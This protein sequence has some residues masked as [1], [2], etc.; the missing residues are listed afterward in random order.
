MEKF[1]SRKI[2]INKE[3]NLLRLDQALA[4]LSNFT[5]SQIKILI[6]NENVIKKDTAVKDASYRV[7][8]GE[9]YFLKLIIPKEEKFISED[10]PLDIIFEDND[11]IVINK[12]AGMVTHPAPGNETGTLVNA[13]LNHT[14]RKLSTINEKN[15]PGIVHRLDKETS[16]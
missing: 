8:K 16:G 9:E 1:Y 2:V 6:L 15:R 5:R 4:R 10:I 14:D 7:K 12:S 11:I 13:L 3:Q